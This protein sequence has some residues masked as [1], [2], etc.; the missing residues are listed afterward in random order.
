MPFPIMAIMALASATGG[1]MQQQ[2]KP[3]Q[4]SEAWLQQHFGPQVQAEEFNKRLA[5]LQSSPYGQQLFGQAETMAS[6]FQNQMQ[7]NMANAG[8]GG[9]EG[10]ETG[11]SI[12]ASSAAP[13]ISAGLRRQANAQLAPIAQQQADDWLNTKR[14][15]MVQQ[16]QQRLNAPTAMQKWGAA[17]SNAGAIGMA[18]A[19]MMP[20]A[21]SKTALTAGDKIVQKAVKASPELLST[22][23]NTLSVRG[24]TPRPSMPSVGGP[25]IGP[26]NSY[27]AYMFPPEPAAAAPRR[28]PA[29]PAATQL[30]PGEYRYN[31]WDTGGSGRTAPDA[32]DAYG[33][34]NPR[35]RINM[36]P[37]NPNGWQWMY[38]NW[39]ESPWGA[40][41]IKPSSMMSSHGR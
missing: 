5:T 33:H 8:L 15:I 35:Y 27:Q 6:Q 9:S 16:E 41:A 17:L 25:V 36:R 22:A 18:A 11:G 38:R 24:G 29:P 28:L 32:R 3:K 21:A 39:L 34:V 26:E 13:Q 19:S 37:V 7:A 20:E 14:N 30:R 2:G 1:L 12:F 31:Q 10:T 40:N 4:I 23:S